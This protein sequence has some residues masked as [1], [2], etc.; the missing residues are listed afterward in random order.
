MI[1]YCIIGASSA[2]PRPPTATRRVS[3]I[4]SV[5]VGDGNALQRRVA[6]PS[7]ATPHGVGNIDRLSNR[8][9]ARP[10][11]AQPTVS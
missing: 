9:I 2:K 6:R 4:G 3:V 10:S 7:T 11:T 5:G 8:R 1:T